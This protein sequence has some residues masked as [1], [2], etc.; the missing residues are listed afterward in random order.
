MYYTINDDYNFLFIFRNQDSCAST[1]VFIASNFV[2]DRF[3]CYLLHKKNQLICVEF[4]HSE[5]SMSD[6]PFGNVT[7]LLA[8]DAAYLPVIINCTNYKQNTNMNIL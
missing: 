5:T 4:E 1:K 2:G 3:L 6:I 7:I 8:K